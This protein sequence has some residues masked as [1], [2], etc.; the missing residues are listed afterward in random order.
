MFRL[1]KTARVLR[2][3]VRLVG[4]GLAAGALAAPCTE[5]IAEADAAAGQLTST[6][7]LVAVGRFLAEDDRRADLLELTGVW[8]G[9]PRRYVPA[10]V[11]VR[12]EDGRGAVFGQ[13]SEQGLAS[14]WSDCFAV[15]P[16]EVVAAVR[17]RLGEASPPPRFKWSFPL[18]LA[19]VIA[20]VFTIFAFWFMAMAFTGRGP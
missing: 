14:L 13:K 16:D 20:L 19:F 5:S 10:S 12:L 17:A 15:T 3:L 4:C 7:D 18:V 1:F 6:A 9:E 2:A 8:L 11:A